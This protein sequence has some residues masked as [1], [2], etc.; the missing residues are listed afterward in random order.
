MSFIVNAAALDVPRIAYVNLFESATT[1]TA[2]SDQ[3]DFEK[4]NAYDWNLYTAWKPTGNG[5]SFLMASFSSAQTVNY[6]CLFGHNLHDLG[7]DVNLEYSTNGGSTW[8]DATS[9]NAPTSGRVIFE[10]FDDIT[11]ADWRVVVH[12]K[13]AGSPIVSF[14]AFGEAVALPVGMRK[15]FTPPNFAAVNK[16]TNQTTEAGVP[17]P[18]T[19]LRRAA[20]FTIKLTNLDP[21]WVRSTFA[22]FLSHAEVKPFIFSWD[23]VA[24]TTEAAFCWTRK[25]TKTS[26]SHDLYMT[27]MLDV[28]ALT[29]LDT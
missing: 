22:A 3:T 29:V 13:G 1:V 16:Y 25:D 6:F 8:N 7:G 20:A 21:A 27:S 14:A 24:H 17:L 26:Y 9:A 15:G 23:S 2:T 4:E 5:Q 18:R 28:N 12:G 10:T 11:A 19:L